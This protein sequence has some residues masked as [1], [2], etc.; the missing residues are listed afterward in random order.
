M[1]IMEPIFLQ[2]DLKGFIQYVKQHLAVKKTFISLYCC[3]WDMGHAD[4][5]LW[6]NG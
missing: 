6:N 2:I 5:W 1:E 4:E 3:L